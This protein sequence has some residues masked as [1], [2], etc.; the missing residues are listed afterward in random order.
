MLQGAFIPRIGRSIAPRVVYDV[1]NVSAQ[2]AIL[3]SV[4][5]ETEH[6]EIAERAL[7][8]DVHPVDS[9]A[10]RFQQQPHPPFFLRQFLFARIPL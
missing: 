10:R 2:H 7:P 6:R 4:A 3:R 8:L 9:F 5:Q 1:V